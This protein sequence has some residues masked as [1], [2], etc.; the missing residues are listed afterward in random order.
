[1]RTLLSARPKKLRESISRFWNARILGIKVFGMVS[2]IISSE[3]FYLCGDCFILCASL[4][5][6]CTQRKDGYEVPSTLSVSAAD[7]LLSITGALAK[8][9]DTVANRPNQSTITGS[10]QPVALIPNTILVRRKKKKTSRSEDSNSETSC[11]LWNHLE[12]LTRLVQCLFA[13]LDKVP[14]WLE[15]LKE[16]HSGSQKEA[17]TEISSGGALLF[18][19]CWKHYSVLLHMEDQNFSK[20]SNELLE[21]YL[22]G[23]KALFPIVF[24][25][26][27]K[28]AELQDSLK[29]KACLFSICTSLMFSISSDLGI[30]Y[31]YVFLFV[32]VATVR[33]PDSVMSGAVA[34]YVKSVCSTRA[35]V[36]NI[37]SVMA[38]PVLGYIYV[39]QE[40]QFAFL[41]EHD[42]LVK[43]KFDDLRARGIISVQ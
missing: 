10:H 43:A 32:R 23:I 42:K 15:E 34:R 30:D 24:L 39:Q 27:E 25:Q 13:G 41:R 26:L 29:I 18:S 12:D 1:M 31:V 40:K 19:S 6:D 28:A 17:G 22:S 35:G 7:C 11:I 2:I 21:Q 16:H 33:D 37:I 3:T 36:M 4:V 9:D 8:R 14:K 38:W 5:D 20:I